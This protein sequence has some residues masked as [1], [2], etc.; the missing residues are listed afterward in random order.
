[1]Q[2]CLE[3]GF[4][5]RRMCTRRRVDRKCLSLLKP[6]ARAARRADSRALQLPPHLA[7]CIPDMQSGLVSG[8]PYESVLL[9]LALLHCV[10]TS[11][12]LLDVGY[13]VATKD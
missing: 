11:L 6:L 5:L 2:S 8:E 7:H 3:T 1:M 12:Y 10:H 13:S 9:L 4:F